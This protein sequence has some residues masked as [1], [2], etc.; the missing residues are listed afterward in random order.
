[1][2]TWEEEEEGG[3][4]SKPSC[5]TE[6]LWKEWKLRF[7]SWLDTQEISIMAKGGTQAHRPKG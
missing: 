3:N 7:I 4:F 1:M 5:A 6:S 2:S